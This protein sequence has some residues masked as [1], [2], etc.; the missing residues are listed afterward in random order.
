MKCDLDENYFP[1]EIDYFKIDILP[2]KIATE[3][4]MLK[5]FDF[6]LTSYNKNENDFFQISQIESL[7]N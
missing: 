1:L 3:F 6:I 4:S 5:V 2:I 7:K